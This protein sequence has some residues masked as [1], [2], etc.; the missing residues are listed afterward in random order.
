M[1][2]DGR[3]SYADDAQKALADVESGNA[4]AAFL[5]RP[6]PVEDVIAVAA[7]GDYMPAKS[8][9][10]YPKAATGLVFNPLSG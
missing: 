7:A 5:V 2:A 10:F 4:D 6:T 9:L 1:A 8:T 3:L